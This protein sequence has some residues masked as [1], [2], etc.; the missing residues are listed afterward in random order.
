MVVRTKELFICNCVGW[1]GSS[2]RFT[3]PL[4]LQGRRM[5]LCQ[6]HL[7]DIHHVVILSRFLHILLFFK[8]LILTKSHLCTKSRLL[9]SVS[10]TYPRNGGILRLGCI[11]EK[12]AG[13]GYEK[14]YGLM[15]YVYRV[16]ALFASTDCHHCIAS[17]HDTTTPRK[18]ETLGYTSM[19]INT[20]WVRIRGIPFM[21]YRRH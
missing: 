11:C 9:T 12:A 13:K 4:P 2:T 21:S 6:R 8:F 18:N 19:C 1:K 5:E 15:R 16:L 10:T 3:A 17:L 20:V 14:L 7:S